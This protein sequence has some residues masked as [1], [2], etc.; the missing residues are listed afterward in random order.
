MHYFMVPAAKEIIF[1]TG[2]L[3]LSNS[4]IFPGPGKW[5]CYIPGFLEHMGTLIICKVTQLFYILF[6]WF[7]FVLLQNYQKHFLLSTQI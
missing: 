3:L 6:I 5:I 7:S 4:R 2:I 1:S